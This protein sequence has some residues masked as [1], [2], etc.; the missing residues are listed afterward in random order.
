MTVVAGLLRATMAVA[1][2]SQRCLGEQ[3]EGG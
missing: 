2:T 3:S 1:A